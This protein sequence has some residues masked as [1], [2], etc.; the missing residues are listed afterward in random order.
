MPAPNDR[1]AA[2]RLP[3]RA[4]PIS[5]GVAART[6]GSESLLGLIPAL[7]AARAAMPPITKDKFNPH[8]NSRYADLARIRESAAAPLRDNGLCI[9]QTTHWAEGEL[10]LNTSLVH[11]S[12]EFVTF[13]YP[14]FADYGNP[15]KLGAALTYARRLSMQTLLDIA[16]ED[17]DGE[18]AM[19]RGPGR[20]EP[21]RDPRPQGQR[22]DRDRP[23]ED[24]PDRR[25]INEAFTPTQDRAES[26]PSY[27]G[28]RL[29][30]V[31][32]GW[33]REMIAEG[34]PPD[35]QLENKELA[36]EPQMINHLCTRLVELGRIAAPAIGKDGN[37]EVRDPMKARTVV[38]QAFE[39]SPASIKRAVDKHL[40][41]LMDKARARLGMPSSG[42]GEG[43]D[44]EGVPA[45]AE[46]YWPAGRE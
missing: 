36:K 5:I 17:D 27:I 24:A 14:V 39:R 8:F 23:R 25:S 34:V 15:Q 20:Q 38:M 41:E 32:A 22:R 21:R 45:G 19:G 1:E 37:P 33:M 9:I 43:R 26:W 44:P 40:D 28:T 16:P 35:R 42:E 11:T 4:F 12:G 10:F 46:E 30:A 6:R 2:P 31:H 3:A 13:D 7:I 29:R 18:T